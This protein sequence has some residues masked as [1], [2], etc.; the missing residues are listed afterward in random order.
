MK[1]HFKY[2][3]YCPLDYRPFRTEPKEMCSS[4]PKKKAKKVCRKR[5]EIQRQ[6]RQSQ[7][8]R[9]AVWLKGNSPEPGVGKLS[10]GPSTATG[11]LWNPGRASISLKDSKG[12]M[13]LVNTANQ[14]FRKYLLSVCC[15]LCKILGSRNLGKNKTRHISCCH[16]SDILC[17]LPATQRPNMPKRWLEAVERHGMAE[18]P[19]KTRLGLF[20]EKCS[21]G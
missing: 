12:I 6:E 5:G 10:P 15:G 4:K 21:L 18:W 14:S 19:K 9:K 1:K 16:G 11:S 20:R 2:I 17:D 13:W 3:K 8:F 7:L